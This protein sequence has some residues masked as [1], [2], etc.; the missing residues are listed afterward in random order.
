LNL[1]LKKSSIKP[2]RAKDNIEKIQIKTK[3][4]CISDHKIVEHNI[5]MIIRIP[6][7]VGVPAFFMICDV[8]PSSRIGW[9]KWLEDFKYLIN[10]FPKINTIIKEV[11]IAT[12]V[13]KVIYEKTFKNEN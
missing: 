9:L 5:P 4:F 3:I 10:G 8:G 7:K 11:K 2:I 13:L 6:P 1:I 12:P